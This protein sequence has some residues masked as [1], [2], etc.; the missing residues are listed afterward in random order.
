MHQDGIADLAVSADDARALA[1]AIKR[2]LADGAL[3]HQCGE[4]GSERWAAGLTAQTMS[5]M[6]L[7]IYRSL[8]DGVP[9]AAINE[10]PV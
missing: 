9:A 7:D 3:R 10:A 8:L 2:L 6:I 1:D 4:A 5:D